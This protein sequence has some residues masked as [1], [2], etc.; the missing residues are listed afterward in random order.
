MAGES[1][2]RAEAFDIFSKWLAEG[3]LLRCDFDFADLARATFRGRVKALDAAALA[4]LSDDGTAELAL[5]LTS[6]LVFVYGDNR[7]DRIE[8]E[9]AGAVCMSR[10]DAA[11]EVFRDFICLSEAIAP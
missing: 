6:D 5:G 8:G 9:L 2:G 3:T 11:G 4:L 1:I 10:P 7:E